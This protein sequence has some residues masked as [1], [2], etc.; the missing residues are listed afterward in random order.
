MPK[1][2][3][4]R[5]QDHSAQA[6]L[7]VLFRRVLGQTSEDFRKLSLERGERVGDGNLEAFDAEIPGQRESVLDATA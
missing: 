4:E 2:I 1:L 6:R 7:Y 3:R 5:H